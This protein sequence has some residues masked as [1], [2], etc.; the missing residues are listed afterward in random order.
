MTD[1]Q[2]WHQVIAP[3]LDLVRG[4]LAAACARAGRAIEEV[5]LVAV[6]KRKPA[7]AIRAAHA[8][9]LRDF[10][11]NYAQELRDKAEELGDLPDISWH[12]IGPL[13]RN[14]VKLVVGRA[15]WIHTVAKVSLIEALEQ[16]AATAPFAPSMLLQVELAG[17]ASKSGISEAE[18]PK[19]L[20]R[21]KESPLPCRGLMTMPPPADDPEDIT[22][23]FERL[24]DLL[25]QHRLIAGRE[26]GDAF[27]QLS[28]GMSQDLDV[29]IRAG[30][31]MVRV[32]S[33]IFGARD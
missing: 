26:T 15:S 6:S 1:E 28:M 9:G 4:R 25:A 32:G 8:L 7:A 21:A 33:A 10:G 17:E 16:R 13:Q 31:T 24:R 27:D 22:P 19:L 3:R 5:R 23:Y 12:F 11:E 29:A 30:A 2:Q 20:E 18:L 14:K